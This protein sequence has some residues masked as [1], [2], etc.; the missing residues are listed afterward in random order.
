MELIKYAIVHYPFLLNCNQ[1]NVQKGNFKTLNEEIAAAIPILKELEFS[2]IINL[3][4][5]QVY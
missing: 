1:S 3:L 4:Q 2:K 5:K